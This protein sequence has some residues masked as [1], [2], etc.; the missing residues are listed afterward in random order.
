[1][2]PIKIKDIRDMRNFAMRQERKAKNDLM[3]KQNE[4]FK[5]IRK[6]IWKNV[7]NELHKKFIQK[8]KLL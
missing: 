8:S 5:M 3:K 2:L 1:M 6:N 4:N 7:S